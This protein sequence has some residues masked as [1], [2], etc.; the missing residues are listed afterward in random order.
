M[1]YSA[2]GVIAVLVLLIENE[3][4]FLNRS[5]LALKAQRRYRRFLLAVLAYYAT[6][7]LWG[8]IE[9]LKI[10]SL[11]FVDT[12]LY[13]VSMA[14]AVMLSTQFAVASLEADRAEGRVLDLVGR[15]YFVVV[16]ATVAVNVFAP[17]LFSVDAQCVYNALAARYVLLAAV[18]VLLLCVSI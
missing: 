16:A 17:V 14:L 8:I 13:F 11:L 3:E 18:I 1:Y 4:I 5:G 12:S 6:D 10:P 15:G 9:S 7:I 2:I